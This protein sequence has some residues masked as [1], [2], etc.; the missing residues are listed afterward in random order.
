MKPRILVLLLAATVSLGSLPAL[1]TTNEC[2]AREADYRAAWEESHAIT[3]G[4][5]QSAQAVMDACYREEPAPA[6]ES[7]TTAGPWELGV[8]AQARVQG[9]QSRYCGFTEKVSASGHATIEG[10]SR[11][12]GAPEREFDSGPATVT[13]GPATNLTEYSV[14]GTNWA[15]SVNNNYFGYIISHGILYPITRYTNGITQALSGCAEPMSGRLCWGIGYG[16]VQ[17]GA[18]GNYIDA[19]SEFNSC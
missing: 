17:I 15:L 6:E 10:S 8:M 14:T 1:A 3:E 2:D 9:V 4:V 11:I 7:P 19:K 16:Y 12:G 18:G 13:Y 5:L